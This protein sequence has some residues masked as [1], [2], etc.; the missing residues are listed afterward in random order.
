MASN[1]ALEAV[2]NSQPPPRA[3]RAYSLAE[4]A[5][6]GEELSAA[7]R[8][9]PSFAAATGL[10]PQEWA[11]LERRDLDRG[12]GVLTVA[13]T[14]TGGKTKGAPLQVEELAKTSGSRRQV[15]LTPRALAALEVTPARVDT[16]LIFPG[17]AG[18]VLNLDNFRRREWG[19]AIEAGGIAT[20]A[21]IYDLRSTFAS[22]SLAAGVTVFELARVMGTSIQMIE[23]H[24]GTLLGGAGASIAA[25]LASYHAA[26]ERAADRTAQDV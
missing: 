8:G 26:Q 15:P 22:D 7:Y 23:R 9:L 10:R 14:V 17:P 24:R 12:A 13:R 2:T 19:P 5:A 4:L 20:P 16:S 18:G 6:I 11:A 21:R 25:R 3:I 1:P